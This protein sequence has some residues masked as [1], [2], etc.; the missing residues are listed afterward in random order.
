MVQKWLLP[1]LSEVLAQSTSRSGL[2]VQAEQTVVTENVTSR[3]TG[4]RI[5]AAREWRSAIAALEDLLVACAAVNQ[6][7]GD[8]GLVLAGPV[9]ILSHQKV[10]S[11]FQTGIFTADSLNAKALKPF[12]LPPATPTST[13]AYATFEL[14]L[15]PTDP[16]AAE[17][18]CFVSTSTFSLVMVL[19]DDLSGTPA[20]QFSF[21]PVDTEQ[22]WRSLRARVLLASP[23]QLSHLEALVKQFE[24]IAPDYQTVMQFSRQM[25]KHLPE[26]VRGKESVDSSSRQDGPIDEVTQNSVNTRPSAFVQT[27]NCPDVE[28]LQALTHEIRTPLTTI[29]TLTR[30]LLK[31]RDL[32]SD[33]SKRLEIIDRE[34]TEQINRMELIFRAVELATSEFKQAPVHLA[35]TS[36]TQLLQQSIPHWQKQASRRNV[37]LEVLLPQKLP[38][39]VSNPVMLDQVLTGLLETFTRSLPAGGHI[40]VQVTRAGNQLKLQLQSQSH[41]NQTG[42]S[43]NTD[44]EPKSIGQLL[45]FQPETGNLSLNLNVTKNLFEV[46]GGKLIVRQRPQQGEVL[47][48]FLPLEVNSI[49]AVSC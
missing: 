1:T 39:V 29:R 5:K 38:T 26:E 19:G 28:L 2:C 47:T 17:Q 22:A 41:P 20:F 42:K 32:A 48:I 8:L 13:D 33:I 49:E 30:L 25:L 44:S 16:L 12:Q 40:Q 36:L 35:P 3:T 23:H 37:T 6:P 24:P 34:C 11:H 4:E 14:S 15:L 7:D 18:F 9:P 10:I 45:M 46:L 21:D 27:Q 43:T 31:R